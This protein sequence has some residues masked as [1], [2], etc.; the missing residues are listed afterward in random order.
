MQE[1]KEYMKE[2]EEKVTKIEKEKELWVAEKS[3][4]I[5]QRDSE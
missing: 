3:S 5:A 1:I 2:N 4:L